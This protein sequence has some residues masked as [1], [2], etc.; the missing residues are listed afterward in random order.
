MNDTVKHVLSGFGIRE[1]HIILVLYYNTAIVGSVEFGINEENSG[2]RIY[3]VMP[4][5]HT[6]D[7]GIINEQQ[8]HEYSLSGNSL[9]Q[10]I[11]ALNGFAHTC[12]RQKQYYEGCC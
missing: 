1:M 8:L 4:P 3:I 5:S 9:Q 12:T 10:F 6:T 11:Y 7:S 2:P